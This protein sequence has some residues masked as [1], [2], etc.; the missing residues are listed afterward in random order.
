M[1]KQRN[2]SKAHLFWKTIPESWFLILNFWK[3]RVR[4]PFI[5]ILVSFFKTPNL[6]AE[7]LIVLSQK[8][9][10]KIVFYL[11]VLFAYC[12]VLWLRVSFCFVMFLIYSY[13]GFSFFNF[14][15]EGYV[16]SEQNGLAIRA[17]FLMVVSIVV[18]ILWYIS[19]I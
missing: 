15:F 6:C 7:R 19:Y 12:I 11:L 14:I 5:Y 4:H 17:S 1:S 10:Y 18:S 2:I 9:K 13:P 16:V 8:K 3:V